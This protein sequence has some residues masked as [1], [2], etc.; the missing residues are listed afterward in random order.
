MDLGRGRVVAEAVKGKIRR[1][2]VIPYVEERILPAST[3]YTDEFPVYNTLA[4]ER[5]VEHRRIRHAER[6]Y[7]IGDV[8]THTIEGFWSLVKN[9]LRG[10]FHGVSKKHLQG[11]LNEYTF[12]WNRRNEPTPLFWAILDQV[13]KDRLAVD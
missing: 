5:K 4:G 8:H 13:R 12:R 1:T 9:G 10:L 7:V 6:V 3:V 11:Y 2:T